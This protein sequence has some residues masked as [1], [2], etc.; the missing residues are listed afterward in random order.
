MVVTT[1]NSVYTLVDVGDGCFEVTSTN[2]KFA[3]CGRCRIDV[4]PRV[5]EVLNMY[6]L[7]REGTGLEPWMH[8]SYV[9]RIEEGK[10]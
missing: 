7:D 9:T 8:T 4:P 2:P 10:G 1:R 6:R 3:N 5:G